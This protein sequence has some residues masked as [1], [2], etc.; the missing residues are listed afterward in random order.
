MWQIIKTYPLA[1]VAALLVHVL[2]IMILMINIDWP[3]ESSTTNTKK[4]IEVIEAKAV[5]EQ[6]LDAREQQIR[7]AE[8]A[9]QRERERQ[10]QLKKQRELAEQKRREEA[11][12]KQR[13]AEEKKRRE[14]EAKRQ[15][16]LKKQRE[17][18]EQKRQ[19]EAA[20]KQREAEEQRRREEQARKEREAEQQRLQEQAQR[21][22]QE[23]LDAQ[24]RQQAQE[25]QRRQWLE[26]N[27]D[28]INLYKN[29]IKDQITRSWRIPPTAHS[30][31]RCEIMVR[32]LPGG[33]VASVKI[34]QSS[35]DKAFDRSVEDAVK[36]A[37][38]LPVPAV[39][40]GLFN[41]FR[42]LKFTFEPKHKL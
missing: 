5:T 35:G 13:E 34:V 36:A 9:R 6:Q 42:E 23:K 33:D 28:E 41:E 11:A 37:S 1:A 8:Q 15:A 7:E 30:G 16:E 29:R 38:P 17:A 18:E 22:L 2:V 10:V 24:A 3:E 4:N 39:D 19:E 25:E 26:K 12:R 20:R 14:A 32:L 40:S 21:E 27:Q 31:M